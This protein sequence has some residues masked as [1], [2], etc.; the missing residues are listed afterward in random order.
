M[1][2]IIQMILS[3]I[4]FTFILDFFLFLGLKLNYID[5]HQIDIYYNAFFAYNQSIVLFVLFALV[6]GF[7]VMYADTRLAVITVGTLFIMVFATLIPSVGSAL[8]SFLFMKKG[9]TVATD[10]FTYHGDLLYSGRK[11][12]WFYDLELKKVIIL[13]KNKIQG[14]Y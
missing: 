4:F 1:S 8:G 2:K 13:D 3:G 12:V 10:R 11:K 7:I 5:A 14:E 6:I 9:I